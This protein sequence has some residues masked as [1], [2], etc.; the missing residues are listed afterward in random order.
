PVKKVPRDANEIVNAIDEAI[1]P[2]GKVIFQ[3]DFSNMSGKN[4]VVEHY[5]SAADDFNFG[6]LLGAP[7]TTIQTTKFP[8]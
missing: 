3:V 6:F 2:E 7:V 8:I 1:F 4:F 5:R